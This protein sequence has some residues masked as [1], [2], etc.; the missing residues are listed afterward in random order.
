[1]R[2]SIFLNEFQVGFYSGK[3]ASYD[4]LREQ[5]REEIHGVGETVVDCAYDESAPM[6]GAFSPFR[7][8]SSST[9]GYGPQDCL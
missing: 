1:M 5:L 8:A 9:Y 7:A 4:Q 6:T 2:A 3:C